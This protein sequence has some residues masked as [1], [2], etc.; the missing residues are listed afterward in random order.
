MGLPMNV[1]MD[2]TYS[3]GLPCILLWTFLYVYIKRERD[4]YT[5]VRITTYIPK[6][7]PMD[8]PINIFSI[9]LETPVDIPMCISMDIPLDVLGI[10]WIALWIF[11]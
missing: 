3:R 5:C 8:G 4:L 7:F 10:P 11:C 1:R 2:I 6:Y 9:C